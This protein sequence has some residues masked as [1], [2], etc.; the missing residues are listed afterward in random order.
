[1]F[2]IEVTNNRASTKRGELLTKGQIGAQVQFM[3]NDHWVDMKK[4]AVFKRCGKTID[5]V[6]SEWNGDIVTIPSEMT[7]EAGLLVHVGVYGVSEDGKRITPT[8]YAPLG[9]VA[10]GAEPD[11]DPSTNPTLPV[12]SQI[13]A[14]IGDMAALET[15]A[16][17]SLVA[18]INEAAK[19]GG[20]GTGI[21]SITYKGEDEY[22]G[23]IYTVLLTDGTSYDITAPKGAA[24]ITPHIG[25]NGNWYLSSTDTG[26]PSRGETGP[27]GPKG[28]KGEAGPQGL[29][30]ETGQHGPEGATGETG[31]QGPQGEQGLQGIQGETGPQGPKGDKGADG[32]SAYVYAVEGGY[33][34]TEAEF[35][36]KL[37]QEQLAGTT[38]DLTPTQVYNAVSAGIPVKVQYTNSIYGLLSFTAFNVAESL[39]V[40]VSQTIVYYNGVYILAQLLGNKSSNS[41]GVQFARLAQKEDSPTAL[42]NPN[43][44]TFTGAVTGS[45][46]GSSAKTV[47]IPSAVTDDHINSLIDT[48]L[49]VIENGAY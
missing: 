7:E 13:Q 46:D 27:Q 12:W 11:G 40:I 18:A 16:K 19:S 21:E 44:L 8:L 2:V 24:G 17:D 20:D 14:Q 49:G 43:A 39:N 4:T 10:L 28:D 45:Y 23:N 47:N 48:K 6:D 29:Q 37:A 22:G 35:A 25:D 9:A 15:E 38:N 34:G 1:M 31:P 30:G 42:P 5:V 33:T 32:K 36:E 26:K 3:F 41:W